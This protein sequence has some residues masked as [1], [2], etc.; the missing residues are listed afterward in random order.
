[1]IE[2]RNGGLEFDTGMP[3]FNQYPES[4]CVDFKLAGCR[5]LF[6]IADCLQMGCLGRAGVLIEVLEQLV[7]LIVADAG[8]IAQQSNCM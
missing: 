2:H 8:S 3:S 5:R 4:R 1:M 7:V 6:G